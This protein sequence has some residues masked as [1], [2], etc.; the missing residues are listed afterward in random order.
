MSLRLTFGIVGKA[1]DDD[2]VPGFDVVRGGT[3]DLDHTGASGSGDDVG[4][5]AGAAVDI[6]DVDVFVDG[7]IGGFDKVLVDRDAALVV[8]VGAGDPGPVNF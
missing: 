6:P 4:F 1:R 2:Q 3:V 8:Q 5:E 7:E